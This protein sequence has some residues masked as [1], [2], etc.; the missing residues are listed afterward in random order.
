MPSKKTGPLSNEQVA[1]VLGL[2]KG[3]DTVE[4]KLTI[5]DEDRRSTVRALGIDPVEA[6]IRQVVF[7]DTP[8]LD[9]NQ[10]G[11]VVRARRIQGG[12]GDTVVKL[13]PVVPSDLSRE[14]RKN[15][16]FGVEVDAMPGGF[17]CSGS[18]KGVVDPE[19][20]RKAVAGESRIRKLFS[21]QQ[22][23]FV[24][25]HTSGDVDLD[26][27]S[28]LGPIFVLKLK[29]SPAGFGRRMV[30]E[31]WIYPDGSRILELSTKC[32]PGEA[33]DVAAETRSFLTTRGINLEGDQQTKTKTAL[34]FFA[35]ELVGSAQD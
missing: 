20:V 19:A 30:A 14:L 22:R 34:E 8:A 15:P 10:Q 6:Q 2:I 24:S 7:F 35:S 18:L 4:L 31:L 21:K 25:E 3:A 29:F 5:P 27:L 9:L 32:A 1:E 33:F 17:V 23:A 12:S 26:Q 11:V 28:V 13:R 16:S